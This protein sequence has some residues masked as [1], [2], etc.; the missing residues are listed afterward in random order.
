MTTLA[1]RNATRLERLKA[2][3]EAAEM[4]AREKTK[5]AETKVLKALGREAMEAGLLKFS[6]AARKGLYLEAADA[7]AK[8]VERWEKRGQAELAR[9]TADRDKAREPIVIRFPEAVTGLEAA[10]LRDAGFRFNKL[11]GHWEG[12]AVFEEAQ[13]LARA[14]DG[15]IIR[16]G[17][18][19]PEDNRA[20]AA[21]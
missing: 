20:E 14:H 15:R 5:N 4:A 9:E 1:D 12:L 2:N 18:H 11:F 8:A 16:G 7:D 17:R 21:E 3:L 19:E 13:A 10:A 6:A